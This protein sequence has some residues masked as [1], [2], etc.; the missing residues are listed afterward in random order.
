MNANI[1]TTTQASRNNPNRI[2]PWTLTQLWREM[3]NDL[4]Q[5]QTHGERGIAKALC[6]REMRELARK[7]KATRKL[8]PFEQV[9]ADTVGA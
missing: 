8:T 2:E 9:I 6:Y 7:L 1:D 5:C 4:K 3:Q